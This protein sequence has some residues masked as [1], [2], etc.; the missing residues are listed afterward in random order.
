[1][2][3]VMVAVAVAVAPRLTVKLVVL[4]ATAD[5]AMSELPGTTYD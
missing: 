4:V 2:Q 5:L 1:M 3:A